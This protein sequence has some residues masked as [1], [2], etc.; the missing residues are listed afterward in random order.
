MF[1]CFLYLLYQPITLLVIF[2]PQLATAHQCGAHLN[3]MT[4]V[5]PG[6]YACTII[7]VR[8]S[9]LFVGMK[10]V[11]SR[12]L[13]MSTISGI[14]VVTGQVTL[15]CQLCATLHAGI[16]GIISL[17][18]GIACILQLAIYPRCICIVSVCSTIQVSPK[19]SSFHQSQSG[20]KKFPIQLIF[21]AHYSIII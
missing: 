20:Q 2:S 7:I 4:S 8:L 12:D 16:L 15:Q 9:L 13:G 18:L 21:T 1:V 11:K 3:N 14:R 19:Y 17:S 6:L 5:S 10:T